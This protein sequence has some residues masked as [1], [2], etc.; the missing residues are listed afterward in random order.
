MS[1]LGNLFGGSGGQ[2]QTSSTN[3]TTNV[4]YAPWY[5]S[6]AQDLLSRGQA[7]SKT[8][9]QPYDIGQMY[10]P[11]QPAQQQAFNQVYQNQNAYQPYIG[12][13][14]GALNRVSGYDPYQS[15]MPFIQSAAMM[16]T[17]YQAGAP[18]MRSA[19]Q[20]WNPYTQAQYT[21]PFLSG[22]VNYAND[23]A[24]QNFLE[25]TLPGA[26]AQFVKSGGGLGGR[27]YA[28]YMARA[29]RDFNNASIGQAQTAAANNYWQGAGQ[30]NQDLNRQL[31]VGQGLGNLA[32]GS[33]GTLGN[34]GQTAANITGGA[35]NT[36]TGIASAFGNLGNQLSG[37]NIGNTNALLQIG[38]QQ[39]QQAQNPL[40]AAYQQYQQG[41]QFPYN[42]L[43]WLSNLSSGLR[44]PSTQ[45]QQGTS[46]QTQSA[47]NSPSILGGI[48]GAASLASGIPGVGEALGGMTSS[49][50]NGI[51]NLFSGFQWNGMPGSSMMGDLT[52]QANQQL[53]TGNGRVWQRGGH[54]RSYASGGD[55]RPARDARGMRGY[56]GAPVAAPST[57]SFGMSRM[58]MGM[59]R[60][61]GR[62]GGMSAVPGYRISA[63]MSYGALQAPMPSLYQYLAPFSGVQYAPG[64]MTG[65]T[66][67]LP[68]NTA[69]APAAAPAAAPVAQT[70]PA[71]PTP[72]AAELW[73]RSGMDANTTAGY[74]K[75]G[76]IRR[77]SQGGTVPVVKAMN[78]KSKPA[79]AMAAQNAPPPVPMPRPPSGAL[80]RAA[81][82]MT[83]GALSAVR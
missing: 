44:I 61:M 24:R 30:F 6:Y 76:A 26:N 17:G 8:P 80:A 79:L 50:G 74:R 59:L 39:Q 11:F 2:T 47:S 23:L 66:G 82:P 40:T 70:T 54:I 68:T 7:L 57:E 22:S 32:T 41:V 5:E 56:G 73:A 35:V 75:G 52:N 46:T 27:N 10:A 25:K 69:P 34:L 1:F 43:S 78:A 3:S 31:Q 38:N 9:F 37:L 16:P 45:T 28:D 49:L 19:A 62:Y 53:A 55:V 67:A 48:L 83:G 77:Y 58:P 64:Q 60:G 13:G 21:N 51:S 20:T 72:S 4:N 33:Q 42:Q 71:A 14:T 15:G 81:A 18:Y 12:A 65:G 63:P 29:L 36:G